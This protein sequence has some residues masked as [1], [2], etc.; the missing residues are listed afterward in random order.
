MKRINQTKCYDM[1]LVSYILSNCSLLEQIGVRRQYLDCYLK[2]DVHFNW[3]CCII[4]YEN[5]TWSDQIGGLACLHIYN[6]KYFL[7]RLFHNIHFNENSSNI[8]CSST[9]SFYWA[10]L[11]CIIL[12]QYRAIKCR[13]RKLSRAF[14]VTKSESPPPSWLFADVI[15]SLWSS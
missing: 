4:W 5:S 14:T 13:E 15:V 3:T 11:Y 9:T 7:S 10:A 1:K 8:F 2:L 6:T 12:W